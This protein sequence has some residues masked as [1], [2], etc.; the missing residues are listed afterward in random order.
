LISIFWSKLTPS[1]FSTNADETLDDKY[2]CEKLFQKIILIVG[3]FLLPVLFVVLYTIVNDTFIKTCIFLKSV[4]IKKVLI[5]LLTGSCLI[6]LI[7]VFLLEIRK[8]VGIFAKNCLP[9]CT[10]CMWIF[11]IIP[12][13]VAAPA[14]VM[15]M[16]N[17]N[18]DFAN[19]AG[20][21]IS[22]LSLLMMIG[23]S[24]AAIF[25]N[26]IFAQL[27]LEKKAA[28]CVK[29]LRSKL[30]TIA[31]R[32]DESILRLLY[33]QHQLHHGDNTLAEALEKKEFVY[34]IDVHEK[35]PDIL[36]NKILVN[37]DALRKFQETAEK[38]NKKLSEVAA[39]A[40]KAAEE[41]NKVVPKNV[42]FCCDCCYESDEEE[43]LEPAKIAPPLSAKEI[44]PEKKLEAE[45]IREDDKP[46]ANETVDFKCLLDRL[47]SGYEPK[48]DDFVSNT[49]VKPYNIFE[50]QQVN[51]Y[52]A[53]F[54]ISNNANPGMRKQITYEQYIDIIEDRKVST[55]KL[56]EL[57]LVQDQCA[58][59]Y[60][61]QVFKIYAKGPI[62]E[63]QCLWMTQSDFID[64][65]L[66]SG[67]IDT[68][69]LTDEEIEEESKIYYNIFSNQTWLHKKSV[70]FILET[71]ILV[72]NG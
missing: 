54:S 69:S 47:K 17:S 53:E 22:F 68:Y 1:L 28:F 62:Q 25:L 65:C 33:D 2:Y 6:T 35:D 24:V 55:E 58:Q 40:Q 36:H 23:V 18:E 14:A 71:D 19:F 70:F 26:Y 52:N 50:G 67:I 31:V 60:Y 61:D 27:E 11:I 57:L 13:G 46:K 3:G 30:T 5:V 29:F 21:I 20:I 9:L 48:N 37:K 10:T 63:A 41:Q 44:K 39:A 8:A 51:Y 34:Y 64:F 12:L 72:D 16:G 56:L 42:K 4:K 66:A 15:Y 32:G 59:R 45:I 38:D 7:I 43:Q 49:Y